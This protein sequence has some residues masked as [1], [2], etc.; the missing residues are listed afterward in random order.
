[1]YIYIYIHSY[2]I[3]TKKNNNHIHIL[4]LRC[5][6][7]PSGTASSLIIMFV[8]HIFLGWF[9][10]TNPLGWLRHPQACPCGRHVLPYQ[11]TQT[12]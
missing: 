9:G 8:S 2:T 5:D 7:P 3:K 6:S 1:M 10:P 12:A 11:E 4:Q